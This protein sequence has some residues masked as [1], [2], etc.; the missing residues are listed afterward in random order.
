MRNLIFLFSV[1]T[2]WRCAPDGPPPDLS[3]APSQKPAASYNIPYTVEKRIPHDVTCFTQGLIFHN[4][5]LI[6]S[7]GAPDDVPGTR[8][9]IGTVNMTTGNH[10]VKAEIDSKK[11]FGEGLAAIDDKLYWVTWLNQT[12]FV[13]DAYSFRRIGQFNY[14]NKEGWGLTAHDNK[15]VMS[16]GTFNLTYIDP[17]TFQVTK[18]V[19]VTKDGYGLDHLNELEFI[20]GFI[21][22]NI[23]MTNRIVKIDPANGKVVG[24]LDLT[25]LYREAEKIS[26]QLREMNGIAFDPDSNRVIITGKLWPQMYQIRFAW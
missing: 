16:D 19:A 7:T 6:E 3:Q 17:E 2:F 18:T 23:W 21:Y 4:G 25:A 13:F 20:N 22:A 10:D 24:E 9:T 1:A 12:G 8:S 11:Y 26:P 5:Q 15:L 14:P